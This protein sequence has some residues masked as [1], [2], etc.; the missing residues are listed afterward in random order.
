MLHT[1]EEI[2]ANLQDTMANSQRHPNFDLCFLIQANKTLMAW[3]HLN[4]LLST[5][6]DSKDIKRG[7]ELAAPFWKLCLECG[8]ELTEREKETIVDNLIF[9]QS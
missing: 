5:I 3:A 6:R 2:R 1:I 8:I 7:V 4:N 9:E